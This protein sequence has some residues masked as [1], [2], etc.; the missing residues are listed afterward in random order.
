MGMNV[1]NVKLTRNSKSG[2][3]QMV[4]FKCLQNLA[5]VQTARKINLI[6]VRARKN[7]HTACI[8]SNHQK[9]HSITISYALSL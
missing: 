1:Y 9:D 3:A 2:I 6:T 7:E 4:P 5:F 8:L